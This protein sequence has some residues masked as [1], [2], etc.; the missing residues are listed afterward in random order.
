[1]FLNSAL[2][3]NR[4]QTSGHGS[5]MPNITK[6]SL[7]LTHTHPQV[8]PCPPL[9][10]LKLW[11][12]FCS[13]PIVAILWSP[14]PRI[15]IYKKSGRKKHTH[16]H[17]HTHTPTQ[18]PPPRIGPYQNTKNPT[19]VFLP[20]LFGILGF[21]CSAAGPQDRRPSAIN[22]TEKALAES[23]PHQVGIPW[24]HTAFQHSSIFW[25]GQLVPYAQA[26][27]RFHQNCPKAVGGQ[28]GPLSL[29]LSLS[30]S[31]RRGTQFLPQPV[32]RTSNS[33]VHTVIIAKPE[34]K[35]RGRKECERG[36]TRIFLHS[37]PSLRPT[38]PYLRLGGVCGTVCR[39]VRKCF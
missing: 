9:D 13:Q 23:T 39:A 18:N 12:T 19:I 11:V 1:M 7:S 6:R 10:C 36:T 33:N 25:W 5:C 8:I 20:P 31:S 34:K 22:P 16:T 27:L 17:T 4:G 30:S 14:N 35:T 26:A 28:R 38:P 37:L 29:S 2:L 21:V 24:G 3:A 32:L 15:R